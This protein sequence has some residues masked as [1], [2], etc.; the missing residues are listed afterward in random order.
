MKA[1]A[2]LGLIIFG[3]AFW[4][5]YS[6]GIPAFLEKQVESVS[7]MNHDDFDAYIN[8]KHYLVKDWA[9]D[10][11]KVS[12]ET[13]RRLNETLNFQTTALNYIKKKF[14]ELK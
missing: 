5:S 13:Y 4:N 14:K 3:L 8:K 11:T 9:L 1:V 2:F 12:P 6:S 10:T 7:G